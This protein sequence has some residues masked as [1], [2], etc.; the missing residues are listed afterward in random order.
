MKVLLK[1]AIYVDWQTLEIKHTNIIV[2]SGKVQFV[3]DSNIPQKEFEIIDCTGKIVTK[4]FVVG[5]HHA[6]SALS[7]GM[8]APKKSPA[9]FYEIL[10]YV[11]WTLD[12][13]LTSEMNEYSALVTAMACAKSGA[14]FAIDHHASPY[15]IKGSLSTL[16][17]AF[18]TVGVSHLL[19]YEISDRDGEKI[20]I[21]GLEETDSYLSKN[22][23]LVGLHASFTLSDETLKKASALMQKHKSGV[24]IHVAEDTYDQEH[25]LENYNISVVERLNRFGML[26]SSKSILVHCLHLSDVERSLISNSPCW[27]VENTDSN[28]NNNVGYFSG[29]GL[30]QNLMFGTDGMHSDML[31]SA[32][33]SY[34]VGQSFDPMSPAQAYARLRNA[35]RYLSSNGFKG[36]DETNLVVLD[37]NSPTPVTSNNYL[38]HL[39]FGINSTHIR[40]VISNGKIIV[41]DR[42]LTM[43]DEEILLNESKKLA[44]YLWECMAK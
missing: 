3:E 33:S 6:Y 16:A 42:K 20:A 30:G 41:K 2:E 31:Q 23:G 34:F 9:N 44:K 25:C 12:K 22:Q 15:A 28:L 26:N 21:E 29:E 32:K 35:H 4:S 13:C 5:H 14:T 39:F 8:G 37:Y 17:K 38:G 36:D 10:K 27:V 7:R 24:H 40:D 19:C 43:V 11:W 18:E 1:N